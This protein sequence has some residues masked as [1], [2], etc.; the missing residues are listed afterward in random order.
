MRSPPHLA[1]LALFAIALALAAGPAPSAAQ[2][3]TD[4][5]TSARRVRGG[6][7]L[8][9]P[10]ALAV[11]PE[12]NT[13]RRLRMIDALERIEPQ[14][15]GLARSAGLTP[16][17]AIQLIT[18]EANVP[19]FVEKTDSSVSTAL[20]LQSGQ[21]IEV[22]GVLFEREGRYLFVASELRESTAQRRSR[23]R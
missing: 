21:P 20:Q 9:P 19:I 22:V 14:F 17:T 5:F 12:R 4:L 3:P 15:D 18:R 6:V 23:G 10:R 8:V 2:R 7:V 1:W 11:I 13:G 16:Q